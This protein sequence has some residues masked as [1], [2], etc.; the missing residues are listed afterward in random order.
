MATLV[1]ATKL[2]YADVYSG[3][4]HGSPRAQGSSG[5]RTDSEIAEGN[6][7]IKQWRN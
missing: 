4:S 7:S 6:F 1:E 2:G 5:L 3:L